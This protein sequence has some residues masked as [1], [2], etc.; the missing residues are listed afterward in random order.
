MNLKYI[1]FLPFYLIV[2]SCGVTNKTNQTTNSINQEFQIYNTSNSDISTN[3]LNKVE[4]DKI[5]NVWIGT[6][7][8]GLIKFDKENFTNFT[9][10]NSVIEGDYVVDLYFDSNNLWVSYSQPTFGTIKFD[11]NKWIKFP[12]SEIPEL[13]F[14]G[15]PIVG[16]IHGNIYFGNIGSLNILKFD[17]KNSTQIEVPNDGNILAIDIND[18]GNIAVGASA[19]HV[20]KYN[21]WKTYTDD[22]SE[23]RLG[24]VRGVKFINGVLYVGYGGG[25]G[26]GGFSILYDDKW[27]HFNKTN[28]N[29]P[30][31][32]VR[33]FEVDGLGNIWMATNDGAVIFNNKDLKPILFDNRGLGYNT[34]MDIAID[35]DNTVWLATTFGLVK[36]KQ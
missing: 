18:E 22:N 9:K 12:N 4:V 29:I 31:H 19:L 35:K 1:I 23:L 28:S 32:M 34:V 10:E 3:R 2:F 21:K 14:C 36:I 7:D 33:D 5:G 8:N 24:T 15:Y 17:G 30:D 20:F 26:D 11:G 6:M 25:F 27:E 16:D 13:D